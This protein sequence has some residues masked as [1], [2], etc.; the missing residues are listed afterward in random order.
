M[1]STEE[2]IF[3]VLQMAQLKSVVLTQSAWKLHYIS[4]T[5]PCDKTISSI[6]NK[7]K[8]TGS[9]HDAPRCGRPSDEG[10]SD[11]IIHHFEETPSTSLRKA[12]SRLNVSYSTV[13]RALCKAGMTPYRIQSVQLLYE[14]DCA[15]RVTM[16]Q[17][18]MNMFINNDLLA[19]ICYSDEA[20]FYLSGNVHK[21]NCR[22]W[23]KEN[24]HAI[25]G[26][27]N[28]V[29]QSRGV[30]CTYSRQSLRSLFF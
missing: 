13:R 30:V 8:T 21:H 17:Q 22:I 4:K 2:R 19:K 29:T 11:A 1:L 28:T 12:V 24:P 23:A 27:S 3:I 6:F 20:I 15:A 16:C 5:S 26:N 14:D 7:F 25:H 9:V 10:K 18:L